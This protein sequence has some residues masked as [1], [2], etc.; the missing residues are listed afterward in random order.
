[1]CSIAAESSPVLLNC[2]SGHNPTRPDQARTMGVIK[3]LHDVRD[4]ATELQKLAKEINVTCDEA[5]EAQQQG[6]SLLNVKTATLMRYNLNL[7]K[8]A[9][10]RVKGESITGI[11][12]KLVED[13]V[14]LSKLRPLEKKLQHHIDLLLKGGSHSDAN[15]GD[16]SA[17]MHMRPNPSA[18]VVDGDEEHGDGEHGGQRGEKDD[19][20]RPPRLAEVVYDVTEARKRERKQ[21]EKDRFRARALRSEGVREMVAELKGLPEEVNM[22]LHGAGSK[23]SRAVEKLMREDKERKRFEENNFT[24]LTVTKKDRKR[25]RDVERAVESSG[26]D[27]TDEFSGLTS[28]A[29]RVMGRQKKSKSK[30]EGDDND[31]ENDDYRLRKL[32]EALDTSD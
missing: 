2:N 5:S 8:L 7:A 26:I 27:G 23:S 19:T 4:Q 9:L 1:M 31:N 17:Q 13:G 32:E 16:D 15:E 11:A 30:A 20:Y 21:V 29:D 24:R 18:V 3:A 22:N 14:A 28:M 12:T 25:R 6:I 10:A